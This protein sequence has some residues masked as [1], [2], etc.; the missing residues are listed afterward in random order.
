VRTNGTTARV[1]LAIPEQRRGLGLSLRQLERLSGV[2]R[3]TIARIE[4][5]GRVHPALMV[6][7]ATALMVLELH[8]EP[9]LPHAIEVNGARRWVAP[10]VPSLP[11]ELEMAR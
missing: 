9:Q 8:A 7:V 11:A 3:N 10:P 5:G 2:S 6:R 4:R 1:A